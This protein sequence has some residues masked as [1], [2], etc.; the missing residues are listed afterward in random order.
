MLPR[1]VTSAI[2]AQTWTN[3]WSSIKPINSA[4]AEAARVPTLSRVLRA[5]RS[6]MA[7]D[8]MPSTK[9]GSI[10][11]AAATPTMNSDPVSS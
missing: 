7:P 3:P 10:R 9:K 1:A 11:A 8:N 6:A 2:S 5:H 4:T